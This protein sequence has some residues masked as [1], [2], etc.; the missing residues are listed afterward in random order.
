MGIL[1]NIPVVEIGN[2][3][4]EQYV[5]KEREIKDLVDSYGGYVTTIINFILFLAKKAKG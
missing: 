3:E 4:I 2:P 1:C 5:E